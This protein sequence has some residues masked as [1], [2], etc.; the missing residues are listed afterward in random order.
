MKPNFTLQYGIRYEAFTPPTEL[1]G[2]LSDLFINTNLSTTQVVV[3]AN[4][5]ISGIGT[6]LGNTSGS[7]VHGSYNNWSPR[8]GIAWR[9]P[10]KIFSG[11]HATTIRA[12]YGTFFNQGIYQQ[13]VGELSN[14]FPWA[15]LRTAPSNLGAAGRTSP[16]PMAFRPAP[17]PSPTAPMP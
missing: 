7:I 14:Q 8:L 17:R 13:L 10:G 5:D 16:S 15:V 1:N 6:P 9:P 4:A 11:S 2:H 12:G 3:P